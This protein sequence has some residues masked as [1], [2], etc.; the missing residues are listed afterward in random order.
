M[1]FL[2]VLATSSYKWHV[3][4]FYWSNWVPKM[5]NMSDTWHP[6]VLPRHH[7]DIILCQLSCMDGHVSTCGPA[8]WHPHFTFFLKTSNDHNFL[9]RCL[10]EVIHT[11]LE[12]SH[13][14]LHN[15]PI[16]IRIWEDNFLSILDPPR[17]RKELFWHVIYWWRWDGPWWYTMYQWRCLEVNRYDFMCQGQSCE[18]LQCTNIGD[19]KFVGDKV[20]VLATLV[21]TSMVQN[22]LCRGWLYEHLWYTDQVSWK[23]VGVLTKFNTNSLVVGIGV[24]PRFNA[25]TTHQQK[26]NYWP[27]WKHLQRRWSLTRGRGRGGCRTQ[28]STT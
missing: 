16:F 25:S 11:L 5:S 1:P 2:T 10:F 9:I 20:Q 24:D 18:H 27:F 26:P 8:T 3:A 4:L 6:L 19:M 22:L 13:W 14:A 12:G 7:D 23:V 28:V 17:S 15:E 21:R